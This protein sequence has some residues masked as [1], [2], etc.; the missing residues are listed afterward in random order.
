MNVKPRVLCVDDEKNVLDSFRRLL[1]KDFD[2]NTATSGADG[3]ALIEQNGPYAV[4]VSDF[5]MPGMN[6]VEF[7]ARAKEIA[8]DTIRVMLTG[9]AEE[10]TAAQA[11]NDGKIFRFLNKPISSSSFIQCLK[12]SIR[13]YELIHAERDILEKTLK[14]SIEA[15][16]DILS[17][18]NPLAFSRATR[19]QEYCKQVGS[20]LGVE[21]LWQLEVAAMLSHLCFV[22]I[23]KDTLE[24]KENGIGLDPV[25]I[26][27]FEDLPQITN[28]IIGHI[29]RLEPILEIINKA[30]SDDSL[31]TISMSDNIAVC[32]AIFRTIIRFDEL[33]EKGYGKLEA[34]RDLNNYKTRYHQTVLDQLKSI[35]IRE[36]GVQTRKIGINQIRVGMVLNE[37]IKTAEGLTVAPKGFVVNELI[38]QLLKNLYLQ[39]AI[40]E[41]V[42][43][44][45]DDRGESK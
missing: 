27:M 3:I 12:D 24:K 33:I 35:K 38:R 23:P 20:A 37:S 40:P 21:D 7:L 5:K 22:T 34:I 36:L 30:Q 45:I 11:I 29:A 10:N 43:V 6:G 28:K 41:I 42:E 44:Q 13:Q 9:Q 16:T 26:Q 18:A 19:V 17:L 39:D 2:L 14:G 25:E 31:S 8:P 32:A 1:R 15:M 4:V